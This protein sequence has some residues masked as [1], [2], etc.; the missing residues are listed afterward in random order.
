PYLLVAAR[1]FPDQP[2]EIDSLTADFL[3]QIHPRL[4]I[5]MIE[6]GRA[7]FATL[8][9]HIAG[10]PNQG[11]L[12]SGNPIGMTECVL[13]RLGPYLD[14]NREP[15]FAERADVPVDFLAVHFDR[16]GG[17]LHHAA[18]ARAQPCD[19]FRYP[20]L[21]PGDLEKGAAE[22]IRYSGLAQQFDLAIQAFHHKPGAPTELHVIDKATRRRQGIL[23]GGRSKSIVDDAGQADRPGLPRTPR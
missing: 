23:E 11:C 21:L 2:A 19:H 10:S 6:T 13:A 3:D 9:Q 16:A 15:R 4:A 8:A 20:V 17:N 7:G 14:Q 1:R 18:A 22:P 5:I 12:D